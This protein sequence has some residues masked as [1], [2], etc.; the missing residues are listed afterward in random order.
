LGWLRSQRPIT[1][2]CKIELLRPDPC[3]VS[4]IMCNRSEALTRGVDEQLI[5]CRNDSRFNMHSS[6]RHHSVACTSLADS[7][8]EASTV[9]KSW[10][11]SRG[12]SVLLCFGQYLPVCRYICQSP[13]ANGQ[14]Q[15]DPLERFCGTWGCRRRHTRYRH[16]PIQKR[17]FYKLMTR[18][19]DRWQ[20]C[21]CRFMS[22][23]QRFIDSL[24]K[25]IL[26]SNHTKFAPTV[27]CHHSQNVLVT[28]QGR[29][30]DN[31]LYTEVC[32]EMGLSR[33]RQQEE[34]YSGNCSRVNP[35]IKSF[36]IEQLDSH[37]K[38]VQSRANMPAYM[39]PSEICVLTVLDS[40]NGYLVSQDFC[41]DL[42]IFNV[43][44]S[45]LVLGL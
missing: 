10:H 41:C 13:Q 31:P 20:Q 6:G 1:D 5:R 29:N 37:Q 25:Q 38:S 39:E 42:L 26:D 33:Y 45:D 12:L 14:M 11:N 34:I 9:Q 3:I 24:R 23:L 35:L 30:Y 22:V 21:S 8:S 36:A 32:E 27:C 28:D 40:R 44:L 43:L 19:I 2:L 16:S 7:T 4:A 17:W 18:H 15:H